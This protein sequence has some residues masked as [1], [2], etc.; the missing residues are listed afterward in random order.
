MN[1]QTECAPWDGEGRED[2]SP[3]FSGLFYSKQSCSHP[4]VLQ[5]LEKIWLERGCTQGN[6]CPM[7]FSGLSTF[8]NSPSPREKICS[9]IQ[10]A[11]YCTC[12]AP[13][14]GEEQDSLSRGGRGSGIK[15]GFQI[16]QLLGNAVCWC[17]AGI[18][19]PP[20]RRRL[21]TTEDHLENSPD[22]G[23]VFCPSPTFHSRL[24]SLHAFLLFLTMFQ[25]QM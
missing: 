1:V 7:L 15:K 9:Q 19:T 11:S 6:R 16:K 14:Q 20:P 23:W 12:A 24:K 5:K 10:S 13:P 25:M 4:R 3:K 18:Q 17:E 8:L 21:A 2:S 22:G